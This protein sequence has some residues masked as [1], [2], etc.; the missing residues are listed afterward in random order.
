M[1]NLISVRKLPWPP[2]LETVM[3]AD[4]ADEDSERDTLDEKYIFLR[5]L[6]SFY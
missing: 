1:K 4:N 5:V 6:L 2:A 3:A